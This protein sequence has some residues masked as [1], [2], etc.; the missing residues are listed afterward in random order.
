MSLL[1]G[2]PYKGKGYKHTKEEPPV[3]I[4]EWTTSYK[5]TQILAEDESSSGSSNGSNS[6]VQAP[7]DY[8]PAQYTS[9]NYGINYYMASGTL[10]ITKY[11]PLNVPD[12]EYLKLRINQPNQ[13]NI[14]W[15]NIGILVLIKFG[16]IKLKTIGF[17]QLLFIFAFTV[18]QLMVAVFF[19]FLLFL[20]LIKYLK[21]LILPL[22]FLSLFTIIYRVSNILGIQSNQI[23]ELHANLTRIGVNP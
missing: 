14:N 20:K 3:E 18:K 16:L 23:G 12:R 10:P 7:Y 5:P 13:D 17:M 21:I 22:F 4:N 1:D 2:L 11:P 6:Y 19:K 15:R 8:K 9:A